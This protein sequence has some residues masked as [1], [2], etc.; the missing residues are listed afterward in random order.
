M[1]LSC[2][3]TE[4]PLSK[5]PTIKST[6]VQ[7]LNEGGVI[8][9]GELSRFEEI[10]NHGFYIASDTSDLEKNSDI[11]ELGKPSKNGGFEKKLVQN[12]LSGKTFYFKAFIKTQS[13]LLFGKALSFVSKGG[14]LPTI[15]RVEPEKGHLD[16]M[17]KVYGERFG[18]D[19]VRLTVFFDDIPSMNYTVTEK[20]VEV[21]LPYNLKNHEFTI[22]MVYYDGP[23][24][25]I[26]YS[27]ATPVVQEVVPAMAN[28]GD[29]ITLRGN[30]FDRIR[31]KNE[32]YI[33][34]KRAEIIQNSREELKVKIP[35][36]VSGGEL[37]ILVNAQLQSV[38]QELKV[39]LFEPILENFPTEGKV[40]QE[41]EIKGQNF[42]P[43]FYRNKVLIN[44][45][46]AQVT[47]GGRDFLKFIMPDIPYPTGE[48]KLEVVV[49]NVYI[50]GSH[51]IKIKE[52]G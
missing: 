30:H 16:E 25:K 12:I 50:L 9:S 17:I 2:Q 44:G 21:L 11:I 42:N 15:E 46:E 13:T 40:G 32:V 8:V 33:G 51:T 47:D 26:A 24:T 48:A 39:R 4:Q 41:I 7:V 35:E 14:L 37:D 43:E 10:L 20:Q 22:R 49:A 6:K 52:V 27:L 36:D 45:Q 34:G 3:E 5:N 31:E 19:V 38:K 29:V 23:E 18:N 28:I 1:V